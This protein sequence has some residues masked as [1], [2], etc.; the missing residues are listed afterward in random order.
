MGKRERMSDQNVRLVGAFS[1]S[2]YVNQA[3]LFFFPRHLSSSAQRI[4]E[5]PG[6]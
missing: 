5:G 4:E 1:S 3:R 2:K 6:G